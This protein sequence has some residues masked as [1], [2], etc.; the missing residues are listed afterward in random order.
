M[1]CANMTGTDKLPLL[2]IGKSAK[3][4][5]F[6]NVKTLPT[7]YESNHKAWMTSEIF[8]NWLAKLDKTIQNQNRKICMIVDNCPA[9]PKVKGLK[10]IELT[11]LPPNTTSHTQPMDQGVI[12]NLKTHYRKQVILRQLQAADKK[13]ELQ[14][15]ILDALRQLRQS[16]SMVTPTTIANCFSHA[17]F[18]PADNDT[19]DVSDSDEPDDN[20][21]LA[22]LAQINN[23]QEYM[24]IDSDLPVCEELTDDDLIAEFKMNR[25]PEETNDD[26]EDE[27]EVIRPTPPISKVFEAASVFDDFFAAEENCDE[28]L[29]LLCKLRKKLIKLDFKKRLAAKQC[30]ITNFL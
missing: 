4:R 15:T 19:V 17:N 29:A 24:D 3:P 16:W 8:T 30:S 22:R 14:I 20:I 28:E 1:I 9:H 26:N 5:C 11:F 7:K 12:K 21:P 13:E 2:I 18:K 27:P 10:A 6:K 23:L 25:N